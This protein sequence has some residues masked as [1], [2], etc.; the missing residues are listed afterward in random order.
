MTRTQQI[1]T[2]LTARQYGGDFMR[3]LAEAGLAADPDN[4]AKVFATWPDLAKVFGPNGVMYREDL[5]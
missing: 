5:G 2:L 1:N 4:R 3:H